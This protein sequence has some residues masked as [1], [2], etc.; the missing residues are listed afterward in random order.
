MSSQDRP[1]LISRWLV[2]F[3][4]CDESFDDFIPSLHQVSGAVYFL[5]QHI[6]ICQIPCGKAYEQGRNDEEI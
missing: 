6:A 2:K 5:T 4:I 1:N 3:E